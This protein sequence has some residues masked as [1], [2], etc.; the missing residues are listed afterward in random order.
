MAQSVFHYYATDNG[1]VN[2]TWTPGR[3]IAIHEIRFHSATAFQAGDTLLVA[4][5]SAISARYDFAFLRVDMNGET[6]TLYQ[7]DGCVYVQGGEVIDATMANS[8]SDTW[9]IDIVWSPV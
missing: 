2:E 6:Q 5:D 8:G 9:S 1:A 3:T 4:V 7:P